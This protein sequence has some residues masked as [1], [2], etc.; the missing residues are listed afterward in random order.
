LCPT[1][2]VHY[3]LIK[4]TSKAIKL[5]RNQK[6]EF[7]LLLANHKP[8][9]T[10]VQRELKKAIEEYGALLELVTI[11]VATANCLGYGLYE[12]NMIEISDYLKD[13]Y[14]Y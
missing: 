9:K 8:S 13:S 4:G 11:R 12:D 7:I 14:G 5:D 10:L 1:L 6:P 3:I 2:C